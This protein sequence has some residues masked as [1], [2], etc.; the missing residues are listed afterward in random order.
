MNNSYI[1][2]NMN[3]IEIGIAI[4][5]FQY[6]GIAKISIPS[7][8]PFTDNTKNALYTNKINKSNI[9]NKDVDKLGITACSYQN[10]LE[11]EVPLELYRH[12][13]DQ[14]NERNEYISYSG[15]AGEKF[16]ISFIGG[17]INKPIILRR[18]Q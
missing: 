5:N 13:F 6:G 10:Y 16:A 7:L 8:T 1:D 18:Y 14:S 3:N 12:K 2:G 4:E 17:D 15:S 9:M 11:L